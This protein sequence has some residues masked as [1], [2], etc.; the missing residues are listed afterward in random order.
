MSKKNEVP[1]W[2]ERVREEYD[3]LHD[4]ISKLKYFLSQPKPDFVKEEQWML[5]KIQ[6]KAMETYADILAARLGV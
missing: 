5:M 6:E 3:E 1:A 2:K 4:R